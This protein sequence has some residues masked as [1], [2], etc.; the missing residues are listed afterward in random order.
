MDFDRPIESHFDTA[1]LAQALSAYPDQEL[2][3]FAVHG[4]A[5]KT[6]A[7]NLMSVLGPHLTS[8][9]E[10]F[11]QVHANIIENVTKDW[12]GCY[13]GPMPLAPG[14]S[15]GST[16]K[17][18]APDAK[19][20]TSEYG[21]PR[22]ATVPPATSLNDLARH[23]A[24]PPEVKPTLKA[25]AS[26]VAVLKYAARLWGEDLYCL[27]DDFK[28]YFTQFRL[29][30]SEWHKSCFQ[31]LSLAADGTPVPAWIMEYVLGFGHAA[32]SGIA[33][34]FSHAVLWLLRKRVNA[35]EAPILASEK[36][37]V[38]RAYLDERAALGPDQATLWSAD[39]FTDDG[40]M[41]IVGADRVARILA[42]WGTL[43]KQ[44]G[45]VTAGPHKRMVGCAI[46]WLGVYL[47]TFLGNQIIPRD[48]AI[49]ASTVLGD[50]A[51][52]RPVEFRDYR[53]LMGRIEHFRGIVEDDRTSTYHMYTPFAAGKVNP[54]GR[55]I[56]TVEIAAKA[57]EWRQLL[58]RRPGRTCARFAPDV[59]SAA[60]FILADVWRAFHVFT[61]AALLGA[62]VPGLGGYLAGQY[63][64]FA[65]PE[66]MLG[67]PIP[68]LEFLA[69]IAATIVF[70][71]VL[72]GALAVLVTDSI[73]CQLVICNN[74]AHADEM[75]WLHREL[76]SVIGDRPVFAET[77]HG[78]GET[79]P[80]ADLASRGRL[81]ELTAL[82]GQLGVKP[83]RRPMPAQQFQDILHRFRGR[84]GKRFAKPGAEVA[85]AARKRQSSGG[86]IS[87]GTRPASAR[88]GSAGRV[89]VRVAST[90][91]PRP[92]ARRE[93]ERI[94]HRGQP[95]TQGE[96][97]PL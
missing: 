88:P 68:Q 69:I 82:C 66:D 20:R 92:A 74:S 1:F 63:F 19:R 70:R 16:G 61:D 73:T 25:H 58:L 41:L 54:R 77:R 83:I 79:N 6:D 23:A 56:P 93:L 21:A 7:G 11:P 94:Q 78:Y 29:H 76:L 64:S 43:L 36:D 59:T 53:S 44:I 42:H 14:Y 72:D 39:I 4:A 48:K 91:P 27:S 85:Y 52:G 47:N 18:G 55:V 34:R 30:P 60:P 32:S 37:P 2:R 90:P 87:G 86:V 35:E 33:Q 71:E 84:F 89:D 81:A 57:E 12:Y 75:M 24:W 22:K 13:H 28:F 67:Y 49:K 51:A 8:L 80:C 26:D 62:P 96:D 15:I 5:T 3:S 45:I 50:L 95:L 17:A 97:Q 9:P 38:R 10:G 46:R 65:L 31:W 40:A